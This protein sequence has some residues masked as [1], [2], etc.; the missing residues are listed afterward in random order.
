MFGKGQQASSKEFDLD[1][2][3]NATLNDDGDEDLDMNDPDLLVS[4][5][6]NFAY[7]HTERKCTKLLFF[8]YMYKRNNYKNFLLLLQQHRK[9]K[10]K[11]FEKSKKWKLILILMLL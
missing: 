6:P 11:Q 3:L 8:L 2:L 4:K 7:T 9:S 5:Q 1:A 10:R